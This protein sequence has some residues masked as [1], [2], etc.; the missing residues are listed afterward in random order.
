MNAEPL[1]LLLEQLN[2]GDASAV[3]KLFRN[4]EPYLR[5]LVRR[6]IRPALRAQFDSSDVVQ[7]V[8][9]H[10][11][12]G[13]HRARWRFE[14]VGRLRA[15]LAQLTL[16]RFHNRCRRQRAVL[17]CAE[18]IVAT[19]LTLD[20]VA[21]AGPRPSEV[22]RR[23][24]SWDQM[25]ALCPPAHHELLRLKRLGLTYSEIASRT[26]LHPSSVRRILYE[27]ARRYADAQAHPVPIVGKE[28]WKDVPSRGEGR[29]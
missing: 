3:E 28:P 13:L 9:A 6:R 21:S 11:L 26:G 5:M 24:E 29:H 18:P 17:A 8:W 20:A 4:Y 22:A 12:E 23:N 14:N 10:L 27:L 16:N 7:S 1:D 2:Q 15:F 19:E 25:L